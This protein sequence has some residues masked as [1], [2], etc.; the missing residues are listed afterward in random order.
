[1]KTN[2]RPSG[3][4][5]LLAGLILLSGCFGLLVTDEEKLPD[6]PVERAAVL[7]LRHSYRESTLW[8]IK[9]VEVLGVQQISPSK[10]FIQV[11]DPQEVYCVCVKYEARYKVPWTT[12]DRSDWDKSIRNILVIKSRNGHFIALK[13]SGICP[14]FCQ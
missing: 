4:F 7:G 9:A 10:E 5:F 8:E 12:E 3:I 13:P 11:H 2:F 6:D 14:P 1:M